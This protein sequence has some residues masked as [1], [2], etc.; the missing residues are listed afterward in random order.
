[1]HIESAAVGIPVEQGHYNA[2]IGH[3]LCF[4]L[5]SLCHWLLTTGVFESRRLAR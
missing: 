5:L 2:A 4:G 3:G 1:M